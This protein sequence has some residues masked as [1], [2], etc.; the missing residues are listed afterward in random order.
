MEHAL[1]PGDPVALLAMQ[2]SLATATAEPSRRVALL[3][4]LARAE[5][6]AALSRRVAEPG[7][8]GSV[9]QRVRAAQV[10]EGITRALGYLHEAYEVGVDQLRVVDEIV[11]IT[12]PMTSNRG[13]DAAL[14]IDNRGADAALAIPGQQQHGQDRKSVV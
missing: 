2:R 11:R 14:A 13:A 12:A 3:I 8:A 4:D 1:P 10:E 6:V 5:E 9:A 7:E